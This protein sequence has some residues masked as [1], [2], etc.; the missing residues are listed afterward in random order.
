MVL[1]SID[2]PKFL[3]FKAVVLSEMEQAVLLQNPTAN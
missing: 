1:L 3:W 2:N